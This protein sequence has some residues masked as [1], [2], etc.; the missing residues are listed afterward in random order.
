MSN[1]E[2]IILI[3]LLQ[4]NE[5]LKGKRDK[6]VV[7]IKH[8]HKLMRNWRVEASKQLSHISLLKKKL[9]ERSNPA[10]GQLNIM[11]NAT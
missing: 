5:K 10:G 3:K 1:G 8:L 7:D 2:I 6:A 9:K 11:V 4:K